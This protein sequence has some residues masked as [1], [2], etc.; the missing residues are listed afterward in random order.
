MIGLQ[1][2]DCTSHVSMVRCI[3]ITWMI[4]N[5]CSVGYI[6]VSDTQ[7]TIMIAF[8]PASAMNTFLPCPSRILKI[9]YKKEKKLRGISQS[10]WNISSDDAHELTC[11]GC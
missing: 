6:I 5:D 10:A 4:C 1:S 3:N 8:I 9:F 11:S 7:E 2:D